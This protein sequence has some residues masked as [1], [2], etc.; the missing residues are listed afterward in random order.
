MVEQFC[1]DGTNSPAERENSVPCLETPAICQ[2][3]PENADVL[4][5]IELD[6]TDMSPLASNPSILDTFL[7]MAASDAVIAA[8]KYM[9]QTPQHPE[10]HSILVGFYTSLA[11]SFDGNHW[12]IHANAKQYVAK[13]HNLLLGCLVIRYNASSEKGQY[14]QFHLTSPQI[15]QNCTHF[16]T[17]AFQMHI[18]FMVNSIGDQKNDRKI[19]A[20]LASLQ[21]IN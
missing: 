18:N 16:N 1:L 14:L 4:P 13:I 2:E 8:F 5:A 9:D 7:K 21:A 20:K 12:T 15:N 19:E 11:I 17:S 3:V 6:A 10:R